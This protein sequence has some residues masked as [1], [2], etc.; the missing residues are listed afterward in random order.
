MIRII[1]EHDENEQL[2]VLHGV[3]RSTARKVFEADA[4]SEYL[5]LCGEVLYSVSS[6]LSFKRGIPN[7]VRCMVAACEEAVLEPAWRAR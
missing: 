6:R 4:G 7:C 3:R 1:I 2:G 5:T